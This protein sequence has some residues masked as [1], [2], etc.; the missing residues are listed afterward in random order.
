MIDPRLVR[1]D[2]TKLDELRVIL[3][4]QENSEILRPIE[5][6]NIFIGHEFRVG[7]FI[8]WP[9]MNREAKKLL[10]SI[11]ADLS[12]TASVGSLSVAQQQLVRKTGSPLDLLYRLY[13][14]E[15]AMGWPLARDPGGDG[16]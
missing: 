9:K 7:P 13:R 16:R 8:N 6:K 12:P 1:A 14:M 10:D 15:R 2:A 11:D 5:M 3:S 4:E